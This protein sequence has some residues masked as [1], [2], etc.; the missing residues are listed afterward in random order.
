[1]YDVNRGLPVILQNG[2]KQYVWGVGLAYTASGSSIAVHH[3]DGLGSTR[4]VTTA[5]GQV[6]STYLTD[7]FGVSKLIQGTNPARMQYTGEPRDNET[8]FVYLRARMYDPAVGRF[9]QRDP[10]PGLRA[11]PQS[12]NRY[13][14]VQNV[15]TT[16]VDPTGLYSYKWEWPIGSKS[17]VGSAEAVMTY[18]QQHVRDI[19]PFDT[20]QCA[21]IQLGAQCDLKVG[22]LPAPVKITSVTSTSFTF[23]ALPG[24][25]DKPGSWIRFRVFERDGQIFLEQKAQ[26]QVNMIGDM[27]DEYILSDVWKTWQKQA[28]NLRKAFGQPPLPPP[29]PGVPM[30]TTNSA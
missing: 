12:L 6:E 25:F 19:F 5:A 16:L 29:P 22:L 3:S 20:G 7:D 24:H 1:M 9:L 17:Q 15:P 18:F 4:A 27:A 10:V 11:R 8:G 23:V 30:P 14:Y 28:N 13:S 21:T 2:T 26:A